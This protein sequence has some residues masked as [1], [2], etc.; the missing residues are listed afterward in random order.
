MA[1]AQAQ[2]IEDLRTSAG[3][4][5][6]LLRTRLLDS[7]AEDS[8]DRLSRL[9]AKLLQVPIAFLSM[10]DADRD[11]YKSCVGFDEAFLK[12]RQLTGPTFCHHTLLSETPLV[13][14]D[15]LEDAVYRE[16]PTVKTVGVR[17]YLG[18][19]LIT[20]DGHHLGSFCV[21]DRQPRDW[22]PVEVETVRELAASALREINLRGLAFEAQ[23]VA[24]LAQEA[25]VA[26]ER[27]VATV[28][29]DLRSPL[30]SIVLSFEMATGA[31]SSDAARQVATR[32]FWSA[33]D[34]MTA[35]LT[36]LLELP[37]SA[38]E[39]T[40]MPPER[41]V[42]DAISMMEPLV[43]QKRMR[44]VDRTPR[45]LPTVAVDY[46]RTLRVFSN[47]IGNAIKFSPADTEIHLEAA[48]DGASVRFSVSDSGCGIS[49]ADQSRVFEANWQ[50]DRQDLRGV[51]LGLSI[52][53]EIV[54][55]QGGTVGVRSVENEGSTFFFTLP[56]T[57]GDGATALP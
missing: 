46:R 42:A 56:K 9:A 44:L 1:A 45:G 37:D 11:F 36:G 47:L 38:A 18:V 48:E 5:R 15:T 50:A 14:N 21:V 17:A 20:D 3:R 40:A 16:V 12:I 28:A 30:A 8:F 41:L 51:G 26:K 4:V 22:S 32:S 31:T 2:R 6:A 24:A 43:Q 34:T 57:V 10:I 23:R 13:I 25:I 55:D 27:M 33:T 53:R 19:P 35:M 49:D 39:P 29:H 54:E 52:V 7:P